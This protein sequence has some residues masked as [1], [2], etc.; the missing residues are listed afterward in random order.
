MA[1]Y[2][3][4]RPG[5]ADAWGPLD[6][7]RR[8]MDFALGRF[9]GPSTYS[10]AGRGIYPAVNL[11][12]T[13]D[14]YVVSAEVPGVDPSDIDVSLEGTTLTLTGQRKIEYPTQDGSSLHRR[15]RQSG[16]FRRAVQLPAEIE[17]DK[18]EAAYRNGVLMVR[19]PKSPEHKPRQ[20]SVQA[21]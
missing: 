14:S 12:E 1:Q 5:A 8:E 21:S 2:T 18:V 4:Y 13:E 7:L 11:H 20:I 9:G 17:V 19:L 16:S 10:A 6:Q 15:E 3:L